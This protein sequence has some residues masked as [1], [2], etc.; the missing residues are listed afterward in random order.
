MGMMLQ[1]SVTNKINSAI[2]DQMLQEA[3]IHQDLLDSIRESSAI[4]PKLKAYEDK[5]KSSK[6]SNAALASGYWLRKWIFNLPPPCLFMAQWL[7]VE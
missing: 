7:C 3:G 2:E 5:G 4:C 6:E 1:E